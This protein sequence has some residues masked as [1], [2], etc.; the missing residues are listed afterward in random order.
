M[1]ICVYVHRLCKY[2]LTKLG[3]ISFGNYDAGFGAASNVAL[4]HNIS[5]YY[6]AVEICKEMSGTNTYVAHYK[7]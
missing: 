5:M 7:W 2:Q 6:I 1:S 3:E 4:R